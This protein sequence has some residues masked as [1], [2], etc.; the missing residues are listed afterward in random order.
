MIRALLKKQM[1]EVFAWIYQDKKSGKNRSKSGILMYTALYLFVFG[2]LGIIFYM[3]ADSLVPL[4]EIGF[5]WLFMALMSLIGIALGVFG[6]VFNTYSTL[7]QAKDNELLLAMPVSTTAILIAR[8]AGVYVMGL[9]YEMIVMIP[10]IIVYFMHSE[11]GILGGIFTIL[12]PFILS[13]LVLA[14]SCILG[15]VIAV[16]NS[17]IKNKNMITVV[18]SIAFIVG[19][20]YVYAKAYSALQGIL[21]APEFVADKV[22]G[23]LYPFYHMGLASEGKAISMLIF[24]ATVAIIFGVVYLVLARSFVK[25]ATSN[26]GAAKTKYK[27]KAMKAGSINGALFRKEIRRF[28]G[29]PT[30]ML[31]CGLGILIMPIAAIALFIKGEEVVTVLNS[32]FG[33]AAGIV[34]M[35]MCA[36]ICMSVSMNDITA[37]S[38]SLEGKSLWLVQVFPVSAWQVLMAKLNVHLV[39][40]LVPALFLTISVLWTLKPAVVFV[41]L[42]PVVVMLFTLFM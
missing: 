5:G 17:R 37:P 42:I 36:A 41:I 8:L 22:K 16:I 39:L 33:E 1:M 31:N 29:S 20:Y 18:V 27:E 15:W 40:T 10:T 14:L 9:M 3:L 32:L 30:Y 23:I 21:A 7:Y 24:T 34:P 25:L 26:R 6:S 38:V 12:I 11:F 19:Y 4:M 2:F 35:L 28:M 13:V